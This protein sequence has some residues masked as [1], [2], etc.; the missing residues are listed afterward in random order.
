MSS[1]T[2][3]CRQK[4][5]VRIEGQ[6]LPSRVITARLNDV[7]A[8]EAFVKLLGHDNYVLERQA[9]WPDGRAPLIAVRLLAAG[10]PESLPYDEPKAGELLRLA[11]ATG[12][13]DATTAMRQMA[14]GFSVP[15][16]KRR[17]EAVDA[18]SELNDRR[19]IDWLATALNDPASGVREAAIEGLVDLG[20]PRAAR[21]LTRA[22]EDPSPEVREAAVDGLLAIGG[23]DA[24]PWLERA[25][26]DI[27]P[28]VRAAAITGLR[29]Y[30]RRYN[31]SGID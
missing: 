20:G 21:A 31:E 30:E 9:D 23:E 19:A 2:A 3:C 8:E 11:D 7:S 12:R 22:F 25:A 15:D 29:A 26:A 18:L 17:I 5:G 4:Q 13:S 28:N 16:V 24:R 1:H 14:D 10:D 27:D 6:P